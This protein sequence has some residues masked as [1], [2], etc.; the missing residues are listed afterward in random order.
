MA[1]R[2]TVGIDLDSTLADNTTWQG[3]L[4]I[5]PPLD[6]ARELMTRLKSAGVKL[7]ICTARLGLDDEDREGITD[8]EIEE[9]I[10]K[11]LTEHNIPYDEIRGKPIADVYYDDRVV[12]CNGDHSDA[13]DRIMEFRPW[14]NY[15]GLAKGR[16]ERERQ[17]ERE[18]AS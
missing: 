3:P 7:V 2:Y 4:Q 15:Q 18:S 16:E 6:G 12:L 10:G 11:W 8:E 1:H 5:G 9:A 13:F 14:Q 17:T